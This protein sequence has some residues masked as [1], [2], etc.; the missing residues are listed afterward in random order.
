MTNPKFLRYL[1][2]HF[3]FKGCCIS[4]SQLSVHLLEN[5]P[6]VFFYVGLLLLCMFL[7]FFPLSDLFLLLLFLWFL[8]F[9]FRLFVLFFLF[10]FELIQP[11]LQQHILFL[12]F[13]GLPT[14]LIVFVFFLFE[15]ISS[16]I[17]G[18]FGLLDVP[19]MLELYFFKFRLKI[20]DFPFLFHDLYLVLG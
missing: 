17:L 3:P 1:V 5:F 9:F 20:R 14:Q 15:Q 16:P 6:E 12:I 4:D 19:G 7:M 2:N 11:H 10:L 13:F 18:H 8:D